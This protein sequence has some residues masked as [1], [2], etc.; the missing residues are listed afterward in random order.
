VVLVVAMDVDVDEAVASSLAVAPGT[1][2]EVVVL[3]VTGG[4]VDDVVVVDGMPVARGVVSLLPHAARGS[5]SSRRGAR[6]F[7][8]VRA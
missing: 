7:M 4:S 1:V 3:N 2:V 6:R 8:V 5:R